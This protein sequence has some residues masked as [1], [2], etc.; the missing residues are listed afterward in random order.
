MVQKVVA[1]FLGSQ[2]CYSV[3]CSGCAC[4]KASDCGMGVMHESL[5]QNQRTRAGPCVDRAGDPA[6]P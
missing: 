2:E 4:A 1:T 5:R 3:V 6:F